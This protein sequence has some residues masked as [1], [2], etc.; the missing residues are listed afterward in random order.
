MIECNMRTINFK[1]MHYSRTDQIN[2]AQIGSE[3]LAAPFQ[4][5]TRSRNH[6]NPKFWPSKATWS[7]SPA[8]S[9]SAVICWDQHALSQSE[10]LCKLQGC[11]SH[12]P[13][14]L[15]DFTPM[16]FQAKTKSIKRRILLVDKNINLTIWV[17]RDSLV[18]FV[19]QF[20]ACH[21]DNNASTNTCYL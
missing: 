15:Y 18:C 3:Q 12:G 5:A 8:C 21:K 10:R 6:M 11:I 17:E 20:L 14:T 2:T 1:M 7:S 16:K 13:H 4:L 19:W 9:T